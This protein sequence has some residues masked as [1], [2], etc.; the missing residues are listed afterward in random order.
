MRLFLEAVAI[1]GHV[2]ESAFM[3]LLIEA[4]ATDPRAY[5]IT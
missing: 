1:V 4:G 3:G 5:L 2:L